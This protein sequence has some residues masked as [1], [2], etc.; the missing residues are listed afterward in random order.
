MIRPAADWELAR[1]LRDASLSETPVEILG[2]GSKRN[3]GRPSQTAAIVLTHV[4]RGIRLYEPSEMVMSA[5]SGTLLVDIEHELDQQGQMLAFEP[6]DL[7]PVLGA[8]AGLAT[9]GGLVST[10][11]SGSRRIAVGAARDHVLGVRAVTGGGQVFQSGGRVLK[12]V[13]GYD[14]VR[15]LTGS[16][17]TLGALTEVTFKVLPR[18][19]E[20]ATLVIVGLAS[21]IAVEALC[22]AMETPYD[23]TGALHLEA[24]L[25]ANLRDEQFR[26]AGNALTA[27]RLEGFASF[28]ARRIER[29][30]E[31]LKPYGEVHVADSDVSKG[32]WAELRELSVLAHSSKPLWRI[33]TRPNKGA[34]VVAGIQRYMQADAFFDWSGGLIWLTVPESADAGSTDIRRVLATHGGHATLI[35]ADAS[36][37]AA[38]EVFQPMDHGSERITTGLKQVFDPAGILNPGRMYAH[39]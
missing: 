29:L 19:E 38:I 30:Q 3:G 15:I 1:F 26:S 4:L 33:S 39:I 16:W 14:L 18:P 5:Q 27:I 13:T 23:V 22:A 6:L 37:R 11:I 25:V 28:L 21:D 17:G 12:N 2:G 31:A 8:E 34:E 35:R 32:F 36:V 10:D 9:I 7:G 24:N 20:T